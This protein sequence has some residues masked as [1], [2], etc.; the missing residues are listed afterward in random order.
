VP[1]EKKG[2]FSEQVDGTR[3]AHMNSQLSLFPSHQRD[4]YKGKTS[5]ESFDALGTGIF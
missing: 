1:S 2:R 5:A 3:N 4:V